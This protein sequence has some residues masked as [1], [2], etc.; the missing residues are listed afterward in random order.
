MQ[1]LISPPCT[2]HHLGWGPR[3]REVSNFIGPPCLTLTFHVQ[4]AQ[5]LVGWKPVI[6]CINTAH[7][8]TTQV[9]VTFIQVYTPTDRAEHTEKDDF[10]DQ[11]QET[12]YDIP[13]HDLQLILG[14]FNSL[15]GGDHGG[16]EAVVSLFASS[17]HI[18]DNV[19]RLVSFCDHNDFW[20]RNTFQCCHIP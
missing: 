15:L 17:E 18:S 13:W 5:A 16:F 7:F 2:H 10:Y 11:L 12:L 1:I 19:K 6:D 8:Q 20:I 9:Q 14:D 4:A 3:L